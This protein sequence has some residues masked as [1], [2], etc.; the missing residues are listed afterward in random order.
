MIKYINYIGKGNVIAAGLLCMFLFRTA[1]N[2]QTHSKDSSFKPHGKLWG[3][4]FGDYY[5]KA[6]ADSLGRGGAN[7]YSGISQGHNA[8]QLRRVYLG[9][10]YYISS[11]FTAQVLLDAAY[12]SGETYAFYIKYAN[13]R[14]K[15]I[16]PGTDLIIGQTATPAF[17]ENSEPYWG[18][19]SIEK[20][21]TDIR[22]TPSYDLGVKL[23]GKIGK[24]GN[25]GYNLMVGNST[26]ARQ[27]NNRFK[28]FYGDMYARLFDKRM[29]ID[30]YGD[31]VRLDWQSGFHHARSMA[32]LFI[33][34]TTPYFTFG[35]EGFM[36]FLKN[37]VTAFNNKTVRRD[38][39]NGTAL[40]F[41]LFARGTLID[42][43]LGYFVRMDQY[44][45]NIGYDRIRYSEYT[46]FSRNYEPNNKE[47]FITAG[48]DFT[49]VKEVHLMPNIW[50]NSYV[51]QEQK[52]AGKG[53]DL[54]YRLTFYYIYE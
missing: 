7:Q 45:P 53:Y 48:L 18:Y 42:D 11:S 40:G 39:L 38:T 6:H 44:N 43:K 34:Y 5:Y 16:L 19:R 1:A 23:Q 33:G 8:F 2:G 51:G 13:L 9:Y 12:T 52:N 37:D 47:R 22:G 50:Y 31:Y 28:R 49:P 24:K 30:L 25:Y 20:T 17:S 36:T 15:N 54:V 29:M 26:G 4:A 21:I 35:A 46:A 14:W 41:S 3:Y 27:E 10:D 32:K